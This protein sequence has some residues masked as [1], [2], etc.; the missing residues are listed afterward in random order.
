M[1]A[2]FQERSQLSHAGADVARWR[3]GVR[4]GAYVV[5]GARTRPGVAR[6]VL[7]RFCCG[8]A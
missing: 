8:M 3:G 5:Y 2:R 4:G 1:G 6:V 7:G